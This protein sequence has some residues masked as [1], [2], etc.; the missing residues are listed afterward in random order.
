T[1]AERLTEEQASDLKEAFSRYDENADGCIAT[2]DL[3]ALIKSLGENPSEAEVQSMMVAVD[4]DQSGTIG[5]LNF[6]NLMAEMMFARENVEEANELFRA[7]DRDQRG[8][9][10]ITD[11]RRGLVN[12]GVLIFE[13]EWDKKFREA[14]VDGDGLLNLNEFIRMISG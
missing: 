14:D 2:K 6:L 4:P 9:I 3:G 13:D 12:K 8:L 10:S 7:F 5:L 1:M 11:L